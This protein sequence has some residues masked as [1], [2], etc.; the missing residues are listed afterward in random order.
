MLLFVHDVIKLLK[1]KSEPTGDVYSD[2]LCLKCTN[3]KYIFEQGCFETLGGY[4]FT[5]DLLVSSVVAAK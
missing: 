2:R 4:P 1:K 5:T 3:I